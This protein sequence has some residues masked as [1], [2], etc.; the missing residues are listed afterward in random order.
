MTLSP[1]EMQR[2][3]MIW[4]P[5]DV[6]PFL[7]NVPIVSSLG[8]TEWD[9]IVVERRSVPPNEAYVAHQTHHLLALSLGEP[10]HFRHSFGGKVKKGLRVPGSTTVMP[11]GLL[12]KWR[13]EGKVENLNI[14]LRP[15]FLARVAEP[16]VANPDRIEIIYHPLVLDS[17]IEHIG[18][19]L[20]AELMQG[21]PGGRLF[22]ESLATA[23]VLHLLRQYTAFPA[24]I[25]ES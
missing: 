12:C 19:A 1:S 13:W 23:L 14:H 3:S 11:A 10:Y 8:T 4:T 7:T 24:M 2:P 6:T 9:G 15:E 5:N 21:A 20:L 25:S 17:Q 22:G 18:K 16:H